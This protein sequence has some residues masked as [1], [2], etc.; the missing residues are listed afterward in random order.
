MSQHYTSPTLNPSSPTKALPRYATLEAGP[1]EGKGKRELGTSHGSFVL[2][3]STVYAQL[4][5]HN[6]H[7]HLTGT[8]KE[9]QAMA[10]LQRAE[11]IWDWF[12]P[13]ALFIHIKSGHEGPKRKTANEL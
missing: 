8:G 3:S 4:K 2:V 13:L 7:C 9:G 11:E 6:D 5:D 12:L 10:G 1:L